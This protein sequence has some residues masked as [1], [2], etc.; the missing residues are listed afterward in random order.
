MLDNITI[1]GFRGL[2][3]LNLKGTSKFNLI[4]GPNNSGKS[5]L[6]EALFLHCTPLSLEALISLLSFRNGEIPP[7]YEYIFE[8][9]EW[10]FTKTEYFSASKI[11][12]EGKWEN[13]NRETT[14]SLTDY[15]NKNSSGILPSHSSRKGYKIGT[16][17]FSFKSDEQDNIAQQYEFIIKDYF[18]IDPPDIPSDIRAKFSNPFLHKN[19][20]SGIQEYD[21]SVKKNYNQKCLELMQQIDSDIGDISMLL[22]VIRKPQLFVT[23]K[24]LGRTPINNFG[25][26]VRRMYLIA[27]SM[28]QCEGGVLFIDELESA[29]HS[30]ALNS[31]TNWI[32]FAAK[33]LNIQIFMTTHSLECLDAVIDTVLKSD[34]FSTSDLSL[35]KL[36]SKESQTSC[37]RISGKILR[38][39][40]YELAQDVRW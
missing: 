1:S 36:R 32:L 40:R 35:F 6:L 11:R 37:K 38:D 33:E 27:T 19:P 23:H 2:D 24:R 26:G 34:F 21:K 39:I 9:A 25:D 18:Q 5:S 16:V 15:G 28:A 7:N 8:Q 22:S 12:I 31:L 13:I 10:L 4:V 3:S 14:V 30:K 20:E 29:I 17:C